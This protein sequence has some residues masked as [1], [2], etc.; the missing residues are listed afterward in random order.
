MK[1]LEIKNFISDN[2]KAYKNFNWMSKTNLEIR[3]NKT[4]N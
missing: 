3:L 2:N 1:E 4:I